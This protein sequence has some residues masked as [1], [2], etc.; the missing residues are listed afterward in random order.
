M[1]EIKDKK[2]PAAKR[3][4]EIKDD[5][6]Y[7]VEVNSPR[8]KGVV[9]EMKGYRAKMYIAKKLGKIVK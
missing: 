9:R 4:P 7:Q 2:A 6:T 1:E 5:A 3:G 8:E